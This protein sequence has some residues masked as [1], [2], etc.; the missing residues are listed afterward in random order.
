MA[1]PA[2]LMTK[3]AAHPGDR[4]ALTKPLGTGV[5]TTALIRDRGEP[6]HEAEAIQWMSQLNDRASRLALDAGVRAATDVTG[7]GLL[8]HGLE[9]AQASGVALRIHAPSVPL[10]SGA[11]RYAEMGT[12]PGGSLDNRE[13]FGGRVTFDPA[14]DEPGRML[15][16]DAQ[17]S[18]GLLLCV[19]APTWASLE[20]AARAA[21][22]PLWAIGE[23]DE[24]EGIRVTSVPYQ[25]S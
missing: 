1:D 24:G 15:L 21:Q 18:G 2:R 13:Y 20:A 17:T 6:Q 14:L 11:R 8:G 12:F 3:D 25:G 10:F 5:T 19:P 7:F 23:V 4:L 9:L 16:F 22:Q